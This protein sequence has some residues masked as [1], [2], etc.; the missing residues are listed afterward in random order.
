MQR[1]AT[2]WLPKR[3]RRSYRGGAP[4]TADGISAAAWCATGDAKRSRSRSSAGAAPIAARAPS[5]ARAGSAAR[6]P[7]AS[8]FSTSLDALR[9]R[10]V[11]HWGCLP[12]EGSIPLYEL[13][14]PRVTPRR[15]ALLGWKENPVQAIEVG[16]EEPARAER[17]EVDRYAWRA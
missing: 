15:P 12:H 3:D 2:T 6:R 17:A 9:P 13:D 8:A 16:H 11:L 1:L 4:G 7:R 14:E 10:H 5:G